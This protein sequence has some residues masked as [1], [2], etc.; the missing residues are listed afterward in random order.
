MKLILRITDG[1]DSGRT[2]DIPDG[3]TL[4]IGRGSASDTKIKD[5]RC[6]RINCQLAFTGGKAVLTQNEGANETLV[7]GKAITSVQLQT[8]DSFRVGDSVL[9]LEP[10]GGLD[11]ST[12]MHKAPAKP[13]AAVDKLVGTEFAHYRLDEVVSKSSSGIVYKATDSNKNRVVAVKVLSP[14]VTATEEQRD[15]F[16]R[17]MQ[18]VLPIKHPNIIPIYHAGKQSNLCWTAM[19]FIEGQSM[20]EV[21]QERGI[22]NMLDWKD[23]WKVAVDIGQALDHASQHN[24]V[25]RNLAPTNILCRKSDGVNLL[26]GLMLAKATEGNMSRDITAAGQLVGN[27]AYMSPERTSSGEIDGR[28]DIYELGATLYALLTGR[29]PFEAVSIPKQISMIQ[30]DAPTPPKQ[31]QMSIH[32]MFEGVV[33]TMLKK[34]PEDRYD[35][36]KDLLKGLERVGTFAGL[37]R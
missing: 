32:D 19:E 16:V 3:G 4:V 7:N 26:G 28:S 35:S 36:A 21:I 29:P 11:A 20:E 22:R 6:S 23:V 18:T 31:Y 5:P 24:I 10:E 2:F 33:L 1:P 8:G 9:R 17:A 37:K 12:I 15:R 14:T 13:R 27:V 30:N 34:R 25:H